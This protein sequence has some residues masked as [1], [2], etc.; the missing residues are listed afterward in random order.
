M[1]PQGQ[2]RAQ[3]R[4]KDRVKPLF[5]QLAHLPVYDFDENPSHV[6]GGERAHILVPG[7]REHDGDDEVDARLAF[8][9]DDGASPLKE[10]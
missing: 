4:W 5:G 10:G 9:A 1:E 7:A 3:R 2:G 8:A 6:A